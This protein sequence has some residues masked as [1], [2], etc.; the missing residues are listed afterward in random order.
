MKGLKLVGCNPAFA[1]I[2]KFKMLIHL[3]Q[4][5]LLL[6]ALKSQKINFNAEALRRRGKQGSFVGKNLKAFM[7]FSASLRLR[8]KSCFWF[9]SGRCMTVTIIGL[10]MVLLE[11][12]R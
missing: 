4:V 7:I 2:Q 1:K 11:R 10:V 3:T 5:R 9:V 6:E 12:S 8:V